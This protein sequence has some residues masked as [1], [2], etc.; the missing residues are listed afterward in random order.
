MHIT[1]KLTLISTEIISLFIYWERQKKTIFY[2]RKFVTT[3]YLTNGEK[4]L[5]LR[6]Q[7]FPSYQICAPFKTTDRAVVL[8]QL[9]K[10]WSFRTRFSEGT[11][12]L[13]VRYVP[14]YISLYRFL[15]LPHTRQVGDSVGT[16]GQ[17]VANAGTLSLSLS[18]RPVGDMP[19]A[20][21]QIYHNTWCSYTWQLSLQRGL[22]F[23]LNCFIINFDKLNEIQF[24]Y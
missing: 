14:P 11:V 9:K 1:R 17:S 24:N 13:Y 15:F 10:K 23:F 21:A 19:I 20:E 2:S 4:S 7:N 18:Y 3:W 6:V 5:K 16:W 8:N 12:Y 22:T